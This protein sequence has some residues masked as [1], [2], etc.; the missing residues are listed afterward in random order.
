MVVMTLKTIELA[1]E[2]FVSYSFSS[3][4]AVVPPVPRASSWAYY[5]LEKI[6]VW[7]YHWVLYSMSLTQCLLHFRL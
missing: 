6:F 7:L 4:L 5:Y 2:R 1:E 3:I